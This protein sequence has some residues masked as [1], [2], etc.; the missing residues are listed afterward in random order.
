MWAGWLAPQPLT[1][2]KARQAHRDKSETFPMRGRDNIRW[3]VTRKQWDVFVFSFLHPYCGK[4]RLPRTKKFR[5]FNERL[6]FSPKVKKCQLLNLQTRYRKVIVGSD[7]VWNY[8]LTDSDNS[9][10]LD[11][12]NNNKKKASYAA[13]FGVKELESNKKGYY[14]QALSE[15]EYI[16]VREE[17]GKQIV[18]ELVDNN[19]QVVVDPT[20]LVSKQEWEELANECKF[21]Y[22]NFIFVYQLGVSSGL[23]QYAKKLGKKHNLKV[24]MAPCPLG[25]PISGISMPTI[26][27][28]EWLW[29]IKN[30]T[31]VVTEVSLAYLGVL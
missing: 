2:A 18:E 21:K 11:F 9:F 24:I 7:Q 31:Y 16:S 29:L 23:L 30:A 3:A 10:L 12:V 4:E 25:M 17:Q 13:S 15:F 26:G 27:P 5:K 1:R 19:V 6:H 28:I 14:K 22:K 8:N 20:L